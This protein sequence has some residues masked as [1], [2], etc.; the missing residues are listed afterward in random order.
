M[1]WTILGRYRNKF[2]KLRWNIF[3]QFWDLAGNML[4]QFLYSFWIFPI[5]DFSR[6]LDFVEGP[7]P[8]PSHP[9]R[10]KRMQN[11]NTLL[12]APQEP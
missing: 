8:S 12:Q 9:K 6:L 1:F 4:G 2:F 7:W 11:K 10:L 5:H 3:V